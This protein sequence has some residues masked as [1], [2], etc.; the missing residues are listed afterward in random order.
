MRENEQTLH[1]HAYDFVF[2]L[3]LQ[4]LKLIARVGYCDLV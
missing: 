3:Y 2:L 4:T 1:K